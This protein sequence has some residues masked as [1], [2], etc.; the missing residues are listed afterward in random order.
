MCI[1]D[2]SPADFHIKTPGQDSVSVGSVILTEFGRGS[3]VLSPNV[4]DRSVDP[5]SVPTGRRS[6]TLHSLRAERFSRQRKSAAPGTESK[7]RPGR[8]LW[9]DN[10][11]VIRGRKSYAWHLE[12][13]AVRKVSVNTRAGHPQWLDRLLSDWNSWGVIP[14]RKLVVTLPQAMQSVGPSAR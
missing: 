6:I 4:V 7:S 12:N 14:T 1:R 2:R 13:R 5:T 9:F 3:K 11:W 8:D 10:S